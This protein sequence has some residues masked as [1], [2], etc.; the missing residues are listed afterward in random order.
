M[1]AN[2]HAPLVSR[3]DPDE[4]G[5]T[6]TSD[7]GRGYYPGGSPGFAFKPVQRVFCGKEMAGRVGVVVY[8]GDRL[9]CWPLGWV[10]VCEGFGDGGWIEKERCGD[11]SFAV[12]A[13][14]AL[15]RDRG[16]H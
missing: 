16:P 15:S 3:A 1:A 8:V 7:G 2:G 6:C 14:L 11:F 10:A 13:D 9:C 5:T 12:V 4:L